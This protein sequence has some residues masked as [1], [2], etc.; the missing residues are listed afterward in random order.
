MHKRRKEMLVMTASYFVRNELGSGSILALLSSM[1]TGTLKY[2]ELIYAQAQ[3]MR[4]LNLM[5][6]IKR[7]STLRS[8]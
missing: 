7:K 3:F 6:N 5:A 1:C 8:N 4:S 2:R